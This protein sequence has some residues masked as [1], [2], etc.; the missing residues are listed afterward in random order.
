MLKGGCAFSDFG[1]RR[2]R[3]YVAQELALKGL[4]RAAEEYKQITSNDDA[5]GKFLGTSNAHFA[6]RFVVSSHIDPL[7]LN[8]VK[9]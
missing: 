1:T 8:P 3:S 6:H 7:L 2:R 4:M 9:I 5:S